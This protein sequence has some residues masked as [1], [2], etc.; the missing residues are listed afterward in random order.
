MTLNE[1]VLGNANLF[2]LAGRTLRFTPDGG[3][4]R[5]ENS[6]LRWESD[7]GTELASPQASLHNFAFPF[8]GKSWNSFSVGVTGSIAFAAPQG[9][10]GGVSVDRFA[11]LQDA[12]RTLINTVP[13]ICVFFKPRMSGTRYLKES[14]DRAVITWS[15]T[16]PVGGIQDFTWTPTVNRFQAVLRKDGTIELSYEQVAAKDAIVGLYP[17][18]AAGARKRRSPRADSPETFGG[19]MDLPEGDVREPGPAG[20][21]YPGFHWA[22][23]SRLDG[24]QR[25]AARA[26]SHPDPVPVPGVKVEGNSI[27]VRGTLPPSLKPG[28]QIAVSVDGPVRRATS[29]RE[30]HRN[31]ESRSWISPQLKRR[32]ARLL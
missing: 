2:D 22:P 32:T 29:T 26:T 31:T 13:A 28:R 16:E 30:A 4:Y 20:G 5:I 23:M 17:T 10:G 7:F 12:A 8:S 21:A 9:R 11:Q 1:G 18:I 27:S 14:E 19:L 24:P 3:G 15:L 25:G 6:P